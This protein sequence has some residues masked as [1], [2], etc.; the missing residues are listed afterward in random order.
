MNNKT[1]ISP[2][3]KHFDS[4]YHIVAT[5]QRVAAI[6]LLFYSSVHSKYLLCD[7][8]VLGSLLDS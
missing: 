8:H 2:V 3:I 7:C 6:I 5:Q 4:A 1:H